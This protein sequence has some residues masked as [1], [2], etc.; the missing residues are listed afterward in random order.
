MIG[1]QT[2]G[3]FWLITFLKKNAKIKEKKISN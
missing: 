1:L 3:P 2:D